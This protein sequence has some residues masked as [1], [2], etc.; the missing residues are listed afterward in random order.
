[1]IALRHINL[2]LVAAALFLSLLGVMLIYSA[3]Y[4]AISGTSSTHFARQF[5]WL[6]M[7]LGL[8]YAFINTPLRL[9]DFSA[10]PLLGFSI[11]LLIVVLF[12]GYSKTGA[13]RAL[14]LGPLNLTPSDVGKIAVLIALSRFLAYTKRP[15]ESIWR[16]AISGLLVGIPAI[17][18]MRQPDLGSSLVFVALLFS[19]WYWSGLNPLYLI[20]IISPLVSLLAAFHWV[21]W[22]IYLTLLVLFL[23]F[24]RPGLLFG[25]VTVVANLA[26]GII[27]PFFWNSLAEY[28]KLRILIFLDPG[29]DPNKAG[30]QIIQSKI[31]VG[32][33]GIIGKGYLGG[34]QSQLEFLPERHT[35]FIFSVLAEEF[36]FIG[37]MVV[38]GVF[39]YIVYKGINIALR[40]RSK[41]TSNLAWGATTIIFFQFFINIGMTFGLTPVTGVPLPFL[42]YGGTSL[43]FFWSLIGLLVLADYYWT[44]Y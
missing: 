30:Y 22:V 2:R 1:M 4:D 43:I 32:S 9:I 23:L 24:L 29:R 40:C 41:F 26:F 21:T 7:A 39:A 14:A 20:L 3:R 10:Y 25:I 33:G 19:M 13:A 42:S 36:G 11:I 17:F 27:T 35:D 37:A 16:L 44:E 31:A 18:V 6:L 38:V 5:L 15:P 34:S 8:F 28:Q 12:F